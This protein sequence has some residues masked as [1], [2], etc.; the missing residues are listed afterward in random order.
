MLP[1]TPLTAPDVLLDF[2]V[3]NSRSLLGNEEAPVM[4]SLVADGGD[5]E[6]VRI[7]GH[8]D[9]QA[10]TFLGLIGANGA[11]KSNTLS[12]LA[13]MATAVLDSCR[14]WTGW[15]N[16]P[17]TPFLLNGASAQRSYYEVNLL[18][19]GVRWTYGFEL[20]AHRVEAEWIHSYPD[21]RR[22]TWLD[23]DAARPEPMTWPDGGITNVPVLQRATRDNALVLSTAGAIGERTLA[24]LFH[25][26]TTI[27]GPFTANDQDQDR[28]T[29]KA[30]AH[31]AALRERLGPLLNAIDPQLT[32]ITLDTLTREPLFLHHTPGSTTA[33]PL[34]WRAL[35]R[36]TRSAATTLR[37]AVHAIDHGHRL[38]LDDFGAGLHPRLAAEIVRLFTTPWVNRRRAQLILATHA[39]SLLGPTY[40]PTLAPHHVVLVAKDAAGATS[41]TPLSDFRLGDS[42]DVQRSYL[43]GAFGGTPALVDGVLGRRLHAEA[44]EN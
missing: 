7:P 41:L 43:D 37:L 20:S 11:G 14:A 33:T 13:D 44:A 34:P 26:F 22:H 5:E 38:L 36:G 15:D 21:G 32:G 9:Q 19:A 31:Q 24:P 28:E 6:S 12:A 17:Y 4:L 1:S 2:L 18:L 16:L 3:D 30:L 35:S 39:T 23:R 25:W 8:P 27:T 10:L 40:A 29:F 42:E